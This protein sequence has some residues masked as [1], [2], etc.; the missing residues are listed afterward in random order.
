V[1]GA[2]T[3]TKPGA[4]ASTL[5]AGALIVSTLIASMLISGTL[6]AS[7]LIARVASTSERR[8]EPWLRGCGRRARERG[9]KRWSSAITGALSR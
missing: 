5:I 3:V 6:I 9:A 1:A 2:A 8:V 7:T 4:S